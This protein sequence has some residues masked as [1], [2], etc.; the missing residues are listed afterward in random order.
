MD[1]ENT[2]YRQLQEHLDKLPIGYPK[3]NSGVEIRI[4]QLLFI[5]IEVKVALCLSLGNASMET[6]GKIGHIPILYTSKSEL[7]I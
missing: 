6:V 7:W 2:Y 5:P 1:S 4:L 3:T